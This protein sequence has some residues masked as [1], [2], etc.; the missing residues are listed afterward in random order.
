MVFGRWLSRKLAAATMV[1]LAA[2]AAAHDEPLTAPKQ[3]ASDRLSCTS[4]D[5]CVFEYS[6]CGY[7]P[8]CTPLWRRVTNRA[9]FAKDK[10][11]A[12]KGMR[13]TKCRPCPRGIDLL[14]GTRPI[15]VAGQCTLQHVPEQAKENRWLRDTSCVR[16]CVDGVQHERRHRPAVVAEC[17]TP[18]RQSY[19][20]DLARRCRKKQSAGCCE[21]SVGA[22]DQAGAFVAKG[23]CPKGYV[24]GMLRCP[25][26]FRYCAPK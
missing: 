2:P 6:D 8:A 14:L 12:E 15:C 17:V 9:T 5:E 20:D 7:C 4:H 26:S 23:K 3:P 22:M 10:A 25:G 16:K 1:L 21:A 24:R 19:Y 13:C 18:C 11:A